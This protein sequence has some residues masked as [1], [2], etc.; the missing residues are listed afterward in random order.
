VD[1]KTR[2]HEGRIHPPRPNYGEMSYVG[3]SI[4]EFTVYGEFWYQLR[5]AMAAKRCS[6]LLAFVCPSV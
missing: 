1:Y 2:G 6:G 5:E 3:L 4:V